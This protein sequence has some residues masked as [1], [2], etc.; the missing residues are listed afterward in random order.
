MMAAVQFKR[1]NWFQK[2][3]IW[4]YN[5]SWRKHHAGV[6]SR[7]LDNSAAA[8]NSFTSAALGQVEGSAKIAAQIGVDRIQAAI[9][10]KAQ[11]QSQALR[12]QSVD[13]LA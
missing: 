5:E 10:A 12:P 1:M 4:K 13:L 6:T 11:S 9:S 7:F 8:V 2:V 3:P